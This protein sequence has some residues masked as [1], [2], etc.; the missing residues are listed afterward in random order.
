MSIKHSENILGEV[1][2]A[3]SN[4]SILTQLADM[5]SYLRNTVDISRTFK[6]LSGFKKRLLK[7]AEGLSASIKFEEIGALK[8]PTDKP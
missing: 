7:I 5:V 3:D 2:Y 8:L 1:F 6:E 4:F